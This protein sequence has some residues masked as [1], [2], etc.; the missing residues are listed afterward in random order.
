MRILII[1]DEVLLAKRLERLIKA[2][3]ADIDVVAQLHSVQEIVD[4]FFNL[5]R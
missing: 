1:E 3:D 4:F 5:V 2:I